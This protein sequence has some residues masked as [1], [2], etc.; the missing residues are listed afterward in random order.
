MSAGPTGGGGRG[1]GPRVPAPPPPGVAGGGRG[2]DRD[3]APVPLTARLVCCRCWCRSW[4]STRSVLRGGPRPVPSV[5]PRDLVRGRSPGSAAPHLRP[6]PRRPPPRT[7]AVVIRVRLVSLQLLP[8]RLDWEGNEHNRSYEELVRLLTFPSR[9]FRA[10][11]P[12][13]PF[14]GSCSWGAVTELGGGWVGGQGVTGTVGFPRVGFI[15]YWGGW[16]CFGRKWPWGAA[17]RRWGRLS[18][19]VCGGVAPQVR[20]LMMR[21]RGTRAR[22]LRRASHSASCSH[23]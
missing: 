2:V 8:K 17:G 15:L 14:R 12:P 23:P 21:A 7:R 4:S 18:A 10:P 16:V 6:L 19:A 20:L 11:D 22:E 3:T 13:P 5:P 9:C 1:S